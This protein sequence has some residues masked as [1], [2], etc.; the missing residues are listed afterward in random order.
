[1]AAGS[2][3]R[4]RPSRSE[5]QIISEGNRAEARFR[6][7]G[8]PWRRP[9]TR[10]AG[11]CRSGRQSQFFAGS[12]QGRNT[13]VFKALESARV[14]SVPF[15]RGGLAGLP[16]GTWRGRGPIGSNALCLEWLRGAPVRLPG[17][18]SGRA[19]KSNDQFGIEGGSFL[20]HEVDGAAKLVGQDGVALEPAM[21]GYELGD[22][23][24]CPR[25]WPVCGRSRS[26]RV[27]KIDAVFC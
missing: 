3:A 17:S 25:S 6:Y 7:C 16:M 19:W 18:A 9:F 4:Q 5:A 13:S 2:N 27:S 26:G 22:G 15:K 21:L 8:Q 1:M 24:R 10:E 12:G 11:L 23:W 14:G 20:Q